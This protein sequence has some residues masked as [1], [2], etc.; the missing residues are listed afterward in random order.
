MASPVRAISSP[1]PNQARPRSQDVDIGPD[2][3]ADSPGSP[4]AMTQ[5]YSDRILRLARHDPGGQAYSP[6]VIS[7]FDDILVADSLAPGQGRTDQ[8]DIIPGQASERLGQFLKPSVIGEPSIPDH[9]VGLEDEFQSLGLSGDRCR[10]M[11]DLVSRLECDRPGLNR[12][13][14]EEPGLQGLPPDRVKVARKRLPSPVITHDVQTR[15]KRLAKQ[16]GDQLVPI[17]PGKGGQ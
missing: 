16:N 7:Q 13:A 14:G 11:P 1:E 9:R 6:T 3:G 15:A 5:T 4:A 12:C 10:E 17:F 2:T 8:G